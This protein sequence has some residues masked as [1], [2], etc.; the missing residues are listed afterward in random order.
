MTGNPDFKPNMKIIA[1]VSPW[2]LAFYTLT[3]VG[4]ALNE[5]WPKISQHQAIGLGL[6]IVSLAVTV[7]ASFTVIWRHSGTFVPGESV[8]YVML[9]LLG[10]AV[11]L[12]HQSYSTEH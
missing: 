2:A 5:L 7:Y 11:W 8:Y 3:L 9:V 6:F 12:C 1:D 10:C 4:S